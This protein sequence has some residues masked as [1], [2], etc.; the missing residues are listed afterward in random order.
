MSTSQQTWVYISPQYEELLREDR[1]WE[2]V[3]EVLW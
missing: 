2:S 1:F 3:V